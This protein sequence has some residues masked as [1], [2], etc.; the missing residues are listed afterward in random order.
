MVFIHLYMTR[1]HYKA[2]NTQT[3]RPISSIFTA[4]SSFSPHL[5][6]APLSIR[7][8]SSSLE[9]VPLVVL[10]RLCRLALGRIRQ[11]WKKDFKAG[12]EAAT[13]ARF[14]STMV[15]I[16]I[17]SNSHKGSQVLLITTFK[18]IVRMI[19]ATTTL[20]NIS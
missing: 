18:R 11:Y 13:M 17:V 15:Q 20:V 4:L 19:P 1:S 14:S 5:Q 8:T 3:A 2:C 9:M 12:A 6:S 10:A 7:Y 16:H